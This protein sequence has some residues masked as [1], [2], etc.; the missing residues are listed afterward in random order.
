MKGR[1]VSRTTDFGDVT[2]RGYGTLLQ[3]WH[4]LKKGSAEIPAPDTLEMSHSGEPSFL[5]KM[6]R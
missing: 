2:G 3:P 4:V 1:H 5:Q 6:W